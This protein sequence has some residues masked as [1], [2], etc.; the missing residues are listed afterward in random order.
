M[1][2]E[3]KRVSGRAEAA[4]RGGFTMT[5]SPGHGFFITVAG[6][7]CLL[8]L[9]S[10]VTKEVSR[11]SPRPAKVALVLG[12]GAARG[13]AHIGVLK[14]LESN[15]V[16]LHVIVGSSAGSFIGSL[17][18]YGYNAFQLQKMSFSLE[19]GDLIDLT[20]PDNGFIKGEKLEEYVNRMLDNTPLERLRIPFHAVATDIQKGEE[21]AFGRGNTGTAVRASCAIPGV[22]RPVKIDGRIYV[23]GG[24][25][26][27]V[28]VEAARR[29]G[30]DVVI[31]VDI[32]SGISKRAPEST[33]ET[34]LQSVDIM[35][36]RISG[37]QLAKADVV[38][39]PAVADIAA[40]DF[41]RRHDA[42]LEGEKAANAELPRIM[43]LMERLRQEGRIGQ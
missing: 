18:A 32:S 5:R 21:V 10:C 3:V 42:V 4:I 14:V 20:V 23:D 6:L 2:L 19:K 33:I 16:P 27:P 41:G 26:S 11:P 43:A 37:A 29:L 7:V 8:I 12:S 34:I 35:H 15:R 17:Y 28:P 39:R 31:A 30:A 36:S 13:F 22:F 40:S 1:R 38:I 25:V 24:V 9:A